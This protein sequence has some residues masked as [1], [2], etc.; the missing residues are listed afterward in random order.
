MANTDSISSANEVGVAQERSRG[1]VAEPGTIRV[2]LADDEAT[3]WL[4]QLRRPLRAEGIEVTAEAD[5]DR[6]FERI[7][8]DKPDALLLDVLFPDVT[9]DQK[10]RGKKLLPQIIGE[11]PDIPVVMFTTTLA[12]EAFQLGTRDFPGAAFVFSK[13][14]FNEDWSE[15]HNPFSDLARCIKNA[16]ADAR[17]RTSLDGRLG[18]I[19]GKTPAM[20]ELAAAMLKVAATDLPILVCGESG[21]GKELVAS[22]LH[23]LSRRKA[24]PFVKL[25]CGALSDETLESALFGHEKGAFTGATEARQGLFEAADGGSLFLDE[26]QTMSAR[27]Q[28]SLLR[29][30]QE[31]VIRRMGGTAER[32][33]GV[34]VIAATNEDL[35]SR[36]TLGTF[37]SDLYYRLNRIRLSVPPL[38]DRT[39]DIAKLF[40]RFVDEANLRLGKVVSTQCRRDL[41]E[42]LQTHDWPG[43]VRELQSAIETAMAL[44]NANLLTPED[45]GHLTVRA[46]GSDDATLRNSV[47]REPTPAVGVGLTWAQLKDIK[48]DQRRGLL[49]AYIRDRQSTAGRRPTSAEIAQDLGTSQDNARRILSEAGIRL[50]DVGEA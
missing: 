3:L 13:S 16:V 1:F 6:V 32:R 49:L 35:E 30:L 19:V 42:L 26:V 21:T 5:P 48:G 11:H 25:N 20:R 23:A 17:Q 47:P 12:D 36:V 27:L 34:R 40:A 39:E 50:R 37:R 15:P 22:S 18:F 8:Q 31:S 14:V 46:H 29:V 24:C 28:Q 33:V 45:F 43:N 4:P 7:D 2:L 44:S 41:L 38:R 9:G 10:P